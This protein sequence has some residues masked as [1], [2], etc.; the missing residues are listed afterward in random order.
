MAPWLLAATLLLAASPALGQYRTQVLAG[1][2]QR[3]QLNSNALGVSIGYPGTFG[4]AYRRYLGDTFIEANLLPL[5][6][7]RGDWLAVMFGLKVGHYLV[8]WNRPQMASLLPQT[9][10]LRVVGTASTFFSRDATQTTIATPCA[11]PTCK[12]P[13]K[14][15]PTVEM[16][17]GVGAGVGLEFGAIRRHGFAF[18]VDVMLTATWDDQGFD[19]LVPIP[20]ASMVYAW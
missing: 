5:V 20:Y 8:V 15:D 10:A 2:S 13:T 12:T 1:H 7:D 6:A 17:S 18:A 19:W 3:L 14:V 16:T 4:F 11:G 9:T